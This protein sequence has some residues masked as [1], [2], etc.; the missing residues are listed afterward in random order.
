MIEVR[1]LSDMIGQTFETDVETEADIRSGD[2]I[3]VI[4]LDGRRF[5]LSFV[6]E[7]IDDFEIEEIETALLKLRSELSRYPQ[8]PMNVRFATNDGTLDYQIQ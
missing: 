5:A 4:R 1:V 6:E 2:R 3:F 7:I 8:Q